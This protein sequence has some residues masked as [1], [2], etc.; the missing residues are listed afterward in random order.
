M[1][2]DLQKI[3]KDALADA[4][5]AASPDDEKVTTKTLK[6]LDLALTRMICLVAEAT[7]EELDQA[8]HRMTEIDQTKP[9]L[10]LVGELEARIKR[11]EER[12][13]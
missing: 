3:C 8:H 6:M 12:L 13:S 9:L 7:S 5:A 10:D 1:R 11:L 2:F 4:Q